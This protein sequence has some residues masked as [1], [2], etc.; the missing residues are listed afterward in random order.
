MIPTIEDIVEDLIAGIITKQQAINWL[1]AH[2]DGAVSELRDHFAAQASIGW[3]DTA[4]TLKEDAKSA[5][6]LADAM[7]L[8][9]GYNA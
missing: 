2:A 9:R 1:N 6:E 3:R 5:Y 4:G 7:M 8:A